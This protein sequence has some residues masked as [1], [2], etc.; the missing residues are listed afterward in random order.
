M[1][2]LYAP[3]VLI[4]FDHCVGRID[5]GSEDE[6]LLYHLIACM[7]I[8]FKVEN[9]FSGILFS[10]FLQFCSQLTS[11]DYLAKHLAPHLKVCVWTPELFPMLEGEILANALNFKTTFVCI[12]EIVLTVLTMISGLDEIPDG[13]VSVQAFELVVQESMIRSKICLSGKFWLLS[14]KKNKYN[15]YQKSSLS[16]SNLVLCYFWYLNHTNSPQ[17]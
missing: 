3:R 15:D 8:A 7:Y 5:P 11:Y 6:I 12:E 13:S 4:L 17:I 10:N 14:C 16:L 1:D 2:E 9:G